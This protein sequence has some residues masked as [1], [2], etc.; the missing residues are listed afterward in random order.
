MNIQL[1][2]SWK[3]TLAGEFEK[4]Y[5]Q[6]IKSFLVSEIQ[7]GKIIYPHPKNIFTALNIC[8]LHAVKVVILGQDPY[9]GEGQAHGL[10]FSVQ[11]GIK[12]PPSLRNIYKEL[13]LEYPDFQIPESGSLTHWAEQ[14]V[15]LLNS[16]LT[17]E[18]GNPAS[19][20]R[21]GWEIFTDAIISELSLR[22]TGIIFL[23]WGSFARS[24]KTLIDPSRHHILEAPHPSPF[25]AHSG[26]FGCGH[27]TR[28]NEILAER[29]EKEIEW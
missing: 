5:F 4:T 23:L 22:Q 6:D 3:E 27:F 7:A 18:S 16:I 29:G 11:D 19:H 21:I 15:L 2:A 20:S 10:S 28:V 17:V 24:K 26:F 8:P 25:S 1:E 13:K 9:H 12:L 14:G